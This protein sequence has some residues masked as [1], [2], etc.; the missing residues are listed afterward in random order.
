MQETDLNIVHPLIE[1]YL[2]H[3]S[4]ERDSILTE[5]ETFASK[6]NFPIVGPLVG[7]LLTLF[8]SAANARRIFELGSGFGYSAYWFAKGTADDARVICT[9]TKEENAARAKEWLRRAGLD[10]KVDFRVGDALDVLA[11]EDGPFDIM[12]C[13]IDKHAYPR[14]LSLGIPKLRRGGLFLADNVLWKGRILANTPD[15]TS[16]AI[17]TFNRMLYSDSRLFTTIL[18]IRDG[19]SLSMKL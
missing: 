3:V 10:K 16:A 5:M 14:A 6:T 12:F 15:E 9:D 13:D 8:A 11:S 2:K 1:E 18:P 19:V 17:L 7:R 4:P